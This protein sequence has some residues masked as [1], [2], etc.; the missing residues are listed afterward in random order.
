MG[1][2]KLRSSS[3]RLFRN[4]VYKRVKDHA[5]SSGEV[6]PTFRAP[7]NLKPPGNTTLPNHFI[8]QL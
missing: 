8:P 3:H 1:I 5:E 4:V 6:C 2:A 7:P